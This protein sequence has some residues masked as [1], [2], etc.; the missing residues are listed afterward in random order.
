M[1]FSQFR[2]LLGF[3]LLLVAA[4]LLGC[5]EQASPLPTHE[6]IFT[7]GRKFIYEATHAAPNGHLLSR[8]TVALTCFD[9]WKYDTTQLKLGY[10][11]DATSTP[12]SF[13]GVMEYDTVL[14]SHPPRDGQYRILELSPFPYIKL[15]ARQ[16]QHWQWKLGVGHQWGDA[17]WATW[18]GEMLVTSSYA[19]TGQQL[20]STPLGQLPCWVVQAE[21]TCKKGT[22]SLTS[23]YNPHYGFVRLAYRNLNNRRVT[24]NLVDTTTVAI[25]TPDE[26]LP[27]RFQELGP[28]MEH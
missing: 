26:F 27:K 5:H 4:T 21:A 19:V 25:V 1:I 13:S 11:Y 20:L 6:K 9:I 14:W 16:G 8:D 2:F 28:A 17:Q 7:K 15:P 23:F 3:S 12:S 22:S 10:S 18:Q 24:L